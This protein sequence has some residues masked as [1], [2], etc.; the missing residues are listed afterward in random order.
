W[1]G[2]TPGFQQHLA[3]AKLRA[4]ENNRWVV[5]SANTGV[6]AIINNKGNLLQSL[7]WDKQGFVK[8]NIPIYTNITAYTRYGDYIYE[9][10]QGASFI[11][12]LAL[13]YVGV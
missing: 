6:S 4:I 8:A 2:N 9:M 7:G 13:L 1:W 11:T 10:A 3:Y 12:I 5:R